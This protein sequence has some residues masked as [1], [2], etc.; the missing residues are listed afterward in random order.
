MLQ[1]ISF[2]G[3]TV[4]LY[5]VFDSLAGLTL[6]VYILSHAARYKAL[7]PEKNA[8]K[9]RKAV[10]A[11]VQLAVVSGL[12]YL[13]FS[14]LNRLFANWFTNGNANYFGNLTAWMLVLSVVP[15]VFGV[16]PLRATDLLTPGLPLCLFAA[17]LACVFHGC[18]SGF[19]LP[20]SFYF[21]QYTN[22]YE[23]PVQIVEAAVALGLFFFCL[24]YRKKNTV[25]G[26]VF[27]AYLI[28]YCISRFFTEFLRADLPD[29]AGPFDAYQIMSTVF[30]AA[31]ILFFCFVRVYKRKKKEGAS[32]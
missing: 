6:L 5:T 14:V 9:K 2:M 29:V 19:A 7:M 25:P 21:N 15:A 4:S 23:F 3:N 17:K 11:V 30:L 20:N 27:P 26:S 1:E 18:C 31:G 16:S 13:L 12:L 24:Y 10:P 28:L 8:K 32:K 22:R